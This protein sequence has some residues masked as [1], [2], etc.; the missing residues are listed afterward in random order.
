MTSPS[1]P[2]RLE[3]LVLLRRVKDRMDR[4]Y[5]EPLDV[6]ALSRARA[7]AST[8]PALRALARELEGLWVSPERARLAAA[9]LKDLALHLALAR[10]GVLL[11]D[12]RT[13]D[14]AARDTL[15]A[16]AVKAAPPP[17]E[18]V[19]PKLREIFRRVR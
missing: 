17:P 18:D 2:Q 19:S 7:G 8:V 4:H 15:V 11:L 1:T 6:E 12:G 3:D 13:I 10:A 16:D 9:D 5:A 14:E